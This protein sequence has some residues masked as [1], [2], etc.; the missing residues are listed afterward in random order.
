MKNDTSFDV[1]Y[2]KYRV[3]LMI[4]AVAIFWI[5]E[6]LL[7]AQILVGGGI[8]EN[9]FPL[10]A[11]ELEH[12]FLI[13]IIILL[14]GYYTKKVIR[15]FQR[16]QA[17][18]RNQ[19][20]QVEIFAY[21]VIHDLKAPVIGM[22]GLA[23][24]LLR[25]YGEKLDEKGRNFC[26]G[27]VDSATSVNQLVKLINEY[28]GAKHASL[29]IQKIN[30]H[31]LLRKIKREFSTRLKERRVKLVI[32][33]PLPDV[34]ADE[35]TM[36]RILRNLVDNPVKHGGK[37]LSEIIVGI[38]EDENFFT[39]SVKNDGAGLSL[40]DSEKIFLPF[41]CSASQRSG[42]GL[43]LAIVKEGVERHGGKLWLDPAYSK[44]AAFYFTLAKGI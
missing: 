8:K 34:K 33:E 11:N 41:R 6:S 44:G 18:L 28:I 21:S 24:R 17:E 43:G 14:G 30:M 31:L 4:A 1:W 37:D 23:D 32:R 5:L 40:A 2:L 35:L 19:T 29:H 25:Q 27:I 9:I 10:N 15:K 3:V 13:V 12:R 20:E 22:K 16:M 36:L 42:S 26:R 7:D 39:F 38:E